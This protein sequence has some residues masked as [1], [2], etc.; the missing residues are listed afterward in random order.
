[1]SDELPALPE[2]WAWTRIGDIVQPVPQFNPAA[3]PQAIYRYVD[4]S[5]ISNRSFQIEAPKIVVGAEAPTRARQAIRPGDVLVSTVRPY[6]RNVAL[7]RNEDEGNVGSTAFCVLRSNDSA[8]PGYL[9]RWTLTDAFFEGLVPKQRGISYPAVRDTDVLAQE[10]PLAPLAEQRRI[11][12]KID[13]LFEQSRTT[14]QALGRILPLLKKFRHSV[15]AAAF[16]GDLTHD[17]REQNPDVEPA[18]VLLQH[19]RAERERRWERDRQSKGK[20]APKPPRLSDAC[21]LPTGWTFTT[22]EPLLFQNRGGIKTGP[23]G[24][25]LKKHEHQTKGVPVLGIENIRRMQFVPGSKIHIGPK[26]A[27]ELAAYDAR[28]GDVLI[29]RS[30]TVGEACVVPQGIGETRI[31]TN[32]MRVR[33]AAEGMLPEFFS[34]LFGS[35]TVSNQISALCGGSTRDFLNARILRSLVF[36]LPPLAE[37]KEILLRVQQAFQ[38][39]DTVERAIEAVRR[40]GDKIEQSIL[41]RAFRGELVPQDLNDEPASVLLKRIGTARGMASA[42][43]RPRSDG[44]GKRKHHASKRM[45]RG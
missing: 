17:W 27:H 38:F 18:S 6:L 44:L 30:G 11:V 1:M 5:S 24:S 31:S 33:L 19:I 35:T 37:Q 40:R 28:A 26:K 41:A 25:L 34:M 10:V 12:V 23:F 20:E 29:S 42:S 22:L 45:A 3:T 15:L 9:F 16:R 7:V 14:R 36:P 32:L 2:G 39:A 43:K 4:V 8:D 13:A 21:S